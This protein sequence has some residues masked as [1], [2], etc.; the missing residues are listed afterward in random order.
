MLLSALFSGTRFQDYQPIP[1][2][3]GYVRNIIEKHRGLYDDTDMDPAFVDIFERKGLD[4]PV[5]A[6]AKAGINFLYLRIHRNFITYGKRKDRCNWK[7]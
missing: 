5:K 2:C 4:A 1:W 7:Y 6:L 3:E